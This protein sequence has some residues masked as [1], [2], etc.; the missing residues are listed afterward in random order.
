MALA[1]ADLLT[2]FDT[3]FHFDT[4]FRFYNYYLPA[5]PLRYANEIL[6]FLNDREGFQAPTAQAIMDAYPPDYFAGLGEEE[7]ENMAPIAPRRRPLNGYLAFRGKSQ[8]HS[9]ITWSN[10]NKIPAYISPALS[11]IPQK[12]RS[13][14][15][16]NLWHED[17][18][19]AQWGIMAFAYTTLRDNFE[20]IERSVPRYV[21]LVA[22]LLFRFPP[23]KR[24]IG[25]AGWV[26]NPAAR[27]F[28]MIVPPN[29]TALNIRQITT[30]EDI[31]QFCLNNGFAICQKAT[32]TWLPESQYSSLAV[33]T[34]HNRSIP[35][36]VLDEFDFPEFSL[37]EVFGFDFTPVQPA[38]WPA[39]IWVNDA[40]PAQAQPQIQGQLQALSTNP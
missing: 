40:N 24:Y 26:V 13:S 6:T 2:W 8:V 3:D 12:S 36:L 31:I 27:T 34:Q 14:F 7:P 18:Y 16:G 22:T 37:A 4:E 33:Q 17:V 20:L 30:E 10:S 23:S 15:I 38:L 5:I 21:Q 32:S 1:G 11:G 25:M 29:F 28:Q 39:L 19:Q 35:E 9:G